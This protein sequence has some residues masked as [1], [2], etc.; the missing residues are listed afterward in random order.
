MQPSTSNA[1]PASLSSLSLDEDHLIMSTRPDVNMDDTHDLPTMRVPPPRRGFQ[2]SSRKNNIPPISSATRDS[3]HSFQDNDSGELSV[4]LGRGPS[5]GNHGTPSKLGNSYGHSDIVLDVGHSSPF[6]LNTAAHGRSRQVRKS[7]VA[8]KGDLRKNAQMRRASMKVDAYA[9][10]KGIIAAHPEQITETNDSFAIP[11]MTGIEQ[12]MRPT[13]DTYTP[14]TRQARSRHHLG[15]TSGMIQHVAIQGVPIPEQNQR[16]LN[17]LA[18]LQRQV[19]ELKR[20]NRTLTNSND[21]YADKVIQLEEELKGAQAH[22]QADSA[23]GSDEGHGKSK[24]ATSLRVEN[25][26]LVARVRLLENQ[27]SKVQDDM[28][29]SL[30]GQ[31]DMEA[32]LSL[33][34][35]ERAYAVQALQDSHNKGQNKTIQIKS[36][37]VT[38]RKENRQLRL[39]IERLSKNTA[40]APSLSSLEAE[41]Q[42]LRK[43]NDDLRQ[44]IDEQQL[45]LDE[46]HDQLD[47]TRDRHDGETQQWTHKEQ[48]WNDRMVNGDADL[49][50]ENKTLHGELASLQNKYNADV[51]KLKNENAQKKALER[52]QKLEFERLRLENEKLRKEARAVKDR[53]EQ[54]RQEK[55]DNR[56]AAVPVSADSMDEL[57]QD[58]EQLREELE[59]LRAE[60]TFNSRHFNFK[61]GAQHSR[62]QSRSGLEKGIPNRSVRRTNV[63]EA[64]DDEERSGYDSDNLSTT[65]LGPVFKNI[66]HSRPS[67][68]GAANQRAG[69]KRAEADTFLSAIDT[70]VINEARKRIEEEY[71]ARKSHHSSG[72]AAGPSHSRKSSMKQT[73]ISRNSTGIQQED[74]IS[75]HSNLSRHDGVQDA[76]EN[77]SGRL[78]RKG[79]TSRRRSSMNGDAMT[80]A[81]ILPDITLNVPGILRPTLSKSAR[82]VISNLAPHDPKQCTVCHRIV[83]AEDP[84][85]APP[86]PSFD[87]PVLVSTLKEDAN[88]SQIDSTLRPSE[89]PLKALS[90][91]I[92]QLA[93]EIVHLKL[94]LHLA[95]RRLA[96]HDPSSSKRTRDAIH[97]SIG[98]LNSSISV[99]CDQIYSLYDALEGHK[100]EVSATAQELTDAG[101]DLDNDC[102]EDVQAILS[103]LKAGRRVTIQS[104]PVLVRHKQ[105]EVQ[106]GEDS[107]EL[108]FEGF[109][110]TGSVGAGRS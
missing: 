62:P 107:E 52:A 1:A 56:R 87:I 7:L 57:R 99:K 48:D 61:K 6:Q 59:Q 29:S 81:F 20:H 11:D 16:Q 68:P 23:I 14:R 60:A 27:I 79:S 22:R 34:R 91:V 18:E 40:T 109:T 90:R 50:A 105:V 65:D 80:S 44:T 17:M 49:A 67:T 21:A 70:D 72:P 69:G 42:A 73:N 106:D 85:S 108:S 5:R 15:N 71:Y 64:E 28:T 43:E 95:E 96:S 51:K 26:R 25:L 63:T 47:H 37:V 77:Q 89:P 10:K 46:L 76:D 3:F 30:N 103:E 9:D 74:N 36:E 45:E 78:S 54:E 100:Q 31:H 98:M 84:K 33:A 13:V 39:R 4:E 75:V 41:N 19:N 32:E 35:T 97:A 8:E 83:S 82:T 66:A 12:I 93:D 86:A 102:T 101:M 53:R 110:N 2:T 55:I 104:P 92:R 94:D 38:L 88:V 24:S 58:N